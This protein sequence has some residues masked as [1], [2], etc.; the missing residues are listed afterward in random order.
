MAGINAVHIYGNRR[1]GTGAEVIGGN[2]TD[3]VARL[4][5]VSHIGFNAWNKGTQFIDVLGTQLADTIGGEC[6][7]GDRYVVNGLGPFLGG[8]DDFFQRK[9]LLGQGGHSHAA[10]GGCNRQRQGAGGKTVRALVR[11][12]TIGSL[13]CYC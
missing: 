3:G 5:G 1:I 7:N 9:V 12:H 4:A 13:G 6:V 11:C 10:Q 2:T 8:N